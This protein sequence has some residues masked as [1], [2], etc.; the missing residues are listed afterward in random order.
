MARTITTMS[1]T[2]GEITNAPA[3]STMIT[4]QQTPEEAADSASKTI[5]HARKNARNQS[6]RATAK[7]RMALC[8][9]PTP[10]HCRRDAQDLMKPDRNCSAL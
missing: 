7:Q 10:L 9:I 2:N 3:T 5:F 6:R 4:L 8:A 1:A